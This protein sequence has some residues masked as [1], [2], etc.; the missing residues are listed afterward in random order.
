MYFLAAQ[1]ECYYTDT[2]CSVVP[3]I[4][5]KCFIFPFTVYSPCCLTNM[6]LHESVCIRCGAAMMCKMYLSWILGWLATIKGSNWWTKCVSPCGVWPCAGEL[7]CIFCNYSLTECFTTCASSVD[8]MT[9]ECLV[10][11]YPYLMHSSLCRLASFFALIV[12]IITAIHP[13]AWCPSKYDGILHVSNVLMTSLVMD[14]VDMVPTIFNAKWSLTEQIISSPWAVVVVEYL[15]SAALLNIILAYAKCE[16]LKQR[17]KDIGS[18][19][20]VN[21]ILQNSFRHV[22]NMIE[23]KIVQ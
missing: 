20:A 10:T 8:M 19:L 7:G 6:H 12:R 4:M 5:L 22:I 1:V 9:V 21:Y 16:D 3:T 13:C 17:S 15:I 11:R 2:M 14:S 18:F 23:A